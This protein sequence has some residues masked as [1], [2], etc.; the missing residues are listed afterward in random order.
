MVSLD[1]PKR[2]W[3][4]VSVRRPCSELMTCPGCIPPSSDDTEKMFGNHLQARTSLG[5]GRFVSPGIN[6][7]QIRT[8]FGADSCFLQ[9][10]SLKLNTTLRNCINCALFTCDV[11]PLRLLRNQSML[12]LLAT[13]TLPNVVCEFPKHNWFVR[14]CEQFKQRISY[15]SVSYKGRRSETRWISYI[16]Y[17]MQLLLL[18][19]V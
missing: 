19:R 8:Y 12:V 5:S 2:D 17:L 9:Q 1:R 15:W 14:H 16:Y 10:M 3:L 11:M 13:W 7:P 18:K 6:P 4:Y